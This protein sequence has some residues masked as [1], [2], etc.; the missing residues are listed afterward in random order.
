MTVAIYARVSTRDRGQDTENQLR[1]LRESCG[2]QGWT[3]VEEYIDHESGKTGERAR[4]KAMMAAAREQRFGGV[5]VWALDRLTREG[6]EQTFAYVRALS[7]A[8][9]VF[10]SHTEPQFS[11]GGPCGELMLAI[12]AWIAKQERQRISERTKAG[13]ATARAKGRIGG[14]RPVA[15]DEMRIRELRASGM[16]L[17]EVAL[18]TGVS[19]ATVARVST[20]RRLA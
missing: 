20:V 15:K 9:V 19:R 5:L 1:E 16:S 14:R 2:R 6:I 4:L 12:A 13:L 11:T 18:A 3:V 8:G 17:S 10:V 7:D